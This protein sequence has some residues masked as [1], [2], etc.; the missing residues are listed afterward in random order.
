[1]HFSLQKTGILLIGILLTGLIIPFSLATNHDL[2]YNCTVEFGLEDHKLYVSVPPSLYDYYQGKTH[3]ITDEAQYSDF[4]T[5]D[6]V[7]PV[8]QNIRNLTSKETY[9]DE[10][11]ANAVLM[12]VQQIPYVESDIKYPIETIVDNKGDCDTVSLLA[13]SILKAGGLDV[14]L[15]YYKNAAHMNV[16][17]HLSNIPSS[18]W[19]T[20]PTSYEYKGKEYWV[21]ECTPKTQWRVGDQPDSLADEQPLIIPVDNCEKS[22]PAKIASEL[23]KP[24]NSSSISINLSSPL[25][26]LDY[27]ESN[28]TVSG[29]VSPACNG[30]NVTM[31]LSQDR[32]SWAFYNTETDNNGE[33]SFDWNFASTGTYYIQTSWSGTAGYAGADSET[34]T[35][36]IGFPKSTV[37]F[38]APDF[39]YILGNPGAAT[40][41]LRIRQGI[42]DFLDLDLEGTGVIITGDFI[43]VKSGETVSVKE[44][45]EITLGEQ[46]LRMPLNLVKNDQFCFIMQNYGQGNYKVQVK[47]IDDYAVSQIQEFHEDRTVLLNA[48][49]SISENTWYKIKAKLSETEITAELFDVDGALLESMAIRNEAASIGEI[50]IL[51][52]NNTNK[53]IAFKNLKIETVNQP[54]QPLD[55]N[56]NPTNDTEVFAPYV[57]WAIVIVSAFTAVFYVWKRG[58]TQR[59]TPKH[60]MQT[61]TFVS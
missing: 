13:A 53:A 14:V 41:E 23:N 59:L 60:D 56:V 48:S 50:G 15:F 38:E 61:V 26:T 11:F 51:V 7:A 18:L 24:L 31:Y 47:A 32:T 46:P 12:L 21:A 42:E 43:V 55:E 44:K 9:G 34:L 1:M 16:G 49:E 10:E 19:W 8:G 40:Y 52:A 28:L 39:I 3:T 45:P 35:V 4:V 37:Q 6:A 58:K 17:I 22:P 27:G 29:S 30:A 33:Y 2:T 20:P 36:F 25:S 54:L 57:N 5:P